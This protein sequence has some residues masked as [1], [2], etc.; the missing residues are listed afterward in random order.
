MANSQE[1]RPTEDVAATPIFDGDMAQ[2]A[3]GLNKM[4][5]SFNDVANRRSLRRWSRHLFRQS[6]LN[7]AYGMAS[8]LTGRCGGF[9]YTQ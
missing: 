1:H 6:V 2:K 5:F 4:C 9:R 8:L 7:V 3:Y